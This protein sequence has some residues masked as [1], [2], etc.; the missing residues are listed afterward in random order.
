MRFSP[1]GRAQMFAWTSR[2]L[3]IAQ[4]RG[5]RVAKREQQRYPLLADQTP[6]P[7]PFDADLEARRQD[8]NLRESDQRIRNFHARVW[9][10]AR[11]DFQRGT[12]EQREAIRSAWRAWAGPVTSIYFRY[13]VDLHT[14]VMDLRAA[15][16]NKQTSAFRINL[17][18]AHRAQQ[19]LEL[20]A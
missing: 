7:Q 20:F 8:A 15:A 17:A 10:E 9:R 2:K 19:T 1:F 16:M 13:I 5:A 14:G 6:A 4:G 12:S 18:R 3:A 11:R